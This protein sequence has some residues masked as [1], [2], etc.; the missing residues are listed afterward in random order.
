MIEIA[1]SSVCKEN[2]KKK[3]LVKGYWE[4]LICNIHLLKILSQKMEKKG[5]W[6]FFLIVGICQKPV[7]TQA[8]DLIFQKY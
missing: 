1:H 6:K 5:D 2:F 8:K 4:S 7:K 3:R